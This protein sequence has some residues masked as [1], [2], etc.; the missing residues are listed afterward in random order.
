M[1]STDAFRMVFGARAR[2]LLET[3][4]RTNAPNVNFVP[5]YRRPN[6]PVAR[7]GDRRSRA[8]DRAGDRRGPQGLE[9]Q[10]RARQEER[11]VA[12]RPYSLQ[13]RALP[14][15]LRIHPPDLLRRSGP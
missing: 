8:G 1:E 13:F 3:R 6:A 14:R 4:T 10:V 15:Q 11:T 7:R 12:G 9:D 2:I 5:C